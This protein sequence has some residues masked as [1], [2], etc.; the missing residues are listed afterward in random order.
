MT[1]CPRHFKVVS[2]IGKSQYPLVAFDNA[3][4]NAGIGDYNLVKVS[5]IL[6]ADCEYTEKISLDNG[7]ILYAAYSTLTVKESEIGTTSVAVAI[8]SN[9]K[10]NG[11]IFE[12]SLSD[13]KNDLENIARE[14][15]IEAMEN[16][17]RRISKVL[18]AS[19]EV[20]GEPHFFISSISAVVMW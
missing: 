3:L 18:S 7:S 4:L 2:G 1:F 14:M 17:G 19:K 15:C 12:C 10:D 13:T 11:V 6:P 8:P 5:S 20:I 9:E 16:R